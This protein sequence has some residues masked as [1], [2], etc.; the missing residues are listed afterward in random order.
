MLSVIAN[1]FLIFTMEKRISLIFL[2][3]PRISIILVIY[4][5]I[6]KT[7]IAYKR[8]NQQ[9][10][11]IS[12][13]FKQYDV[14][15]FSEKKTL[16]H[17]LYKD[18]SGNS[19][20]LRKK[21][22]HTELLGKILFL[23]KRYLKHI[24]K[25]LKN[26]HLEH[27]LLQKSYIP[28]YI[29][30]TI[31]THIRFPDVHFSPIHLI[32]KIKHLKRSINFSKDNF[33][34]ISKKTAISGRLQK[35]NEINFNNKETS[36]DSDKKTGNSVEC[37]NFLQKLEE[38]DLKTETKECFKNSILYSGCPSIFD[39]PCLCLSNNYKS[40]VAQCIYQKNLVQLFNAFTFSN[41]TCSSYSSLPDSC[42][43]LFM[44]NSDAI[45][46]KYAYNQ[47]KNTNAFKGESS[48]CKNEYNAC[49]KSF[50]ILDDFPTLTFIFITIGTYIFI[51]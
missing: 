24:H 29:R 14:N 36:S 34:T 47:K 38:S 48:V 31:T 46:K 32:N 39:I 9:N 42:V 20:F 2:G 45:Y 15:K 33:S 23:K 16:Y 27:K 49:S 51:E 22:S 8:E 18:I 30:R 10:H 41:R 17:S 44:K 1:D 40:A 4:F 21:I 50:S 28:P 13:Y 11:N 7:T 37:V 35:R 43:S 19:P 25:Q 26:N 5:C 12:H 6:S 3:N